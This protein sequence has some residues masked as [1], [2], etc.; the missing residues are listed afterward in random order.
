M[1]NLMLK[2]SVAGGGVLTTLVVLAAR[3]DAGGWARR[4]PHR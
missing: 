2:L 3:A 1:R 4:F